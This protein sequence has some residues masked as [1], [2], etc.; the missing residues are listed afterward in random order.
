MFWRN[1]VTLCKKSFVNMSKR[2]AFLIEFKT[3]VIKF[4]EKYSNREIGRKFKIDESMVRR[5]LQK[6]KEINEA[7][8]Q[9]GPS[10]KKLRLEGAGRKPCLSTVEDELMEKIAKE[11]AEQRHVSTKLIQVWA[12]K[13]AEE[14]SLTEFMASRGWLFN[15][16]K[17]YNLSIR[18]QTTTEQSL[19]CDLE[20]KIHNFVAFNKK[21]IDLNSLQPAMIAN[22]DETPIWA[23][24]PS[25]T[26]VD[27]RGIHTVPIKTTG[28]EKTD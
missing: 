27:S 9:P 7:Y 22:M 25:D 8:E 10:K 24:M 23:D 21:Q 15:F 20:D 13:R 6:K 26:T 2:P 4:A 28:H 14:I 5:W 17:R 18:R 11:Q 19:P 16:M 3:E 12:T 1:F